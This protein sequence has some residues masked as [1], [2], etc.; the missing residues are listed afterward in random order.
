[1][2]ISFMFPGQGAQ[3][4]GMGKD[5]Y[6][7]YD[8]IRKVFNKASEITNIDIA[9]LCF[10]GIK[11]EFKLGEELLSEEEKG[12]ELN[13]TEN[14]Q[15]AIATMSLAIVE[16]LK[17]ENI[18]ADITVGL[19]LG[20]YPALIYSGYLSFE[21]GIRL[22]KQRGY[23]MGNR[24]PDEEY[25][26]AAVIGLESSKIEDIC[27]KV[28]SENLFVVPAN[29][30]YSNQT[31]ISGNIEGVDR[32]IEL[33]K[34]AGAKK[35]VKLQTN[36]PFHT[37]KLNDAKKEYEKELEKVNFNRGKVEVIKNIDGTIY[38]E[39]DN[40]KN[41]LADHIVS[42]VRFDKA[43]NLMEEKGIDTYIEIGPGK[44]LSGF[45]KKQLKDL[46]NVKILNI[47]DCTSFD[48]TINEIKG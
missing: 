9:T 29:Y 22:L 41:I 19:S 30:N 23:L 45:V 31:V 12:E 18:S 36:G 47:C 42:P 2:K 6:E 3:Y 14:T 24:I 15:I 33:L 13:K 8:E 11:R 35:A 39:N 40:I 5:L 10:N 26:M 25:S 7:K 48:N 17:K 1:M 28:Q 46:T 20:E 38:T 34:E 16:L 21:D 37:T 32:A 43:I 44:V 4:V 27:K